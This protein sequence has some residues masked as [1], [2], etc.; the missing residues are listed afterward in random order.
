MSEAASGRDTQ[1]V[2][3]NV[4]YAE[5]SAASVSAAAAIAASAAVAEGDDIGRSYIFI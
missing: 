5:A 2:L 1:D 3:A 4:G